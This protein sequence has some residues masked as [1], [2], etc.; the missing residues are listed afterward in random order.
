MLQ[1]VDDLLVISGN[2]GYRLHP[3]RKIGKTLGTEQILQKGIAGG[4]I[5]VADLT[6]KL[7]ILYIDVHFQRLCV[8]IGLCDVV[9][10]QRDLLIGQLDLLLG[11]VDL[12]VDIIFFQLGLFFFVFGGVDLILDLRLLILQIFDLLVQVG[13][14]LLLLCFAIG[15]RG[16]RAGILLR[17]TFRF[18]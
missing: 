12:A 16:R 1:I 13:Q 6:L 4:H 9:F 14:L 2:A 11:V 15:G 18:L 10:E 8:L 7:L 3:H 5:G 17:R